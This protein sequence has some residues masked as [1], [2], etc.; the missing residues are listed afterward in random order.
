MKGSNAGNAFS[1]GPDTLMARKVLRG[2]R[3]LREVGRARTGALFGPS[4]ELGIQAS[5]SNQAL[6]NSPLKVLSSRCLLA[7]VF[8]KT[9]FMWQLLN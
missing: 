8:L 3:E 9:M 4:K 1:T 6:I 7:A 2:R 5:D